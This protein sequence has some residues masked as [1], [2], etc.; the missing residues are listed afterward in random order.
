MP[1]RE[2]FTT[3]YRDAIWPLAKDIGVSCGHAGEIFGRGRIINDIW[4]FRPE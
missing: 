1:S 3:I 4:L 2:P